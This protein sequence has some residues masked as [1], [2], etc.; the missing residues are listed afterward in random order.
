MAKRIP[1]GLHLAGVNLRL[2]SNQYFNFSL[3]FIKR[4]ETSCID[5]ENAQNTAF[6]IGRIKIRLN[7]SAFS[8]P[9]RFSSE[10]KVTSEER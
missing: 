4:M 6:S 2:F 9:Y 8:K 1:N 3:V 5:Y 7:R 10:R